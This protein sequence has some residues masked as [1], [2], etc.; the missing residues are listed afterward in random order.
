MLGCLK[1]FHSGLMI[2]DVED[3]MRLGGQRVNA[4]ESSVFAIVGK[5]LLLE[6]RPD[7]LCALPRAVGL[8]VLGI[9]M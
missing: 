5:H 6:L 8:K 3:L 4:I 2:D 7:A 1:E 9:L